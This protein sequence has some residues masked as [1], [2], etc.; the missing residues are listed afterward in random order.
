MRPYINFARPAYGEEE[1]HEACL[2]AG[3]MLQGPDFAATICSICQGRGKRMQTYTAGCGGGYY[4]STGDCEYCGCTG[5]VQP[6]GPAAESVVIQVI[7]AG[8]SYL[9]R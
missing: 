3:L 4:R 5:L 9:G 6:N 2:R 1:D 8:K 7:N